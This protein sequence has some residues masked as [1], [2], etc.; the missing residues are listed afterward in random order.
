MVAGVECRS[1]TNTRLK[2]KSSAFIIIFLLLLSACSSPKNEQLKVSVNSWIG[3]SPLFYAYEKGWL[4]PYD[5]KVVNV[6]SLAESLYVYEANNA[7][8]F[9][10]TQ[11]EYKVTKQNQPTLIPIM[12]LDKSYGADMVMSNKNI[13]QLQSESQPINTYLEMNSINSVVLKS[14]LD[15][16]HISEKNINY[17][18][19]DQVKIST[20]KI[21]PESKPTMVVTYSPYD[22][23]LQKNGFNT[24]ASTRDEFSITVIDALFTTQNKFTKHKSQF[25][26]LKVQIDRAVEVLKND[27]KEYYEYTKHYLQDISYDEFM[28]IQN[29]I[30]W[31]NKELSPNLKN[32]L[33]KELFPINGLI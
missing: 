10:G 30:K 18:N 16:Y 11:F 23:I 17:V 9:T 3:Y 25:I 28:S 19:Q 13:E 31:I 15:Y 4:K 33:D 2:M 32:M 24:L 21:S 12:M 1:N 8:A 7:D 5:I 26:A 27:P 20:L 14:F 6:V 22:I 29:N